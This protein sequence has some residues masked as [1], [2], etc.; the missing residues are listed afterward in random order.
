MINDKVLSSSPPL[1]S[2]TLRSPSAHAPLTYPLT[3]PPSPLIHIDHALLTSSHAPPHL[4]PPS[5]S[6]PATLLLTS[7]HSPQAD[8]FL[9]H[10]L[11]NA[12][13]VT[14]E[15]N[16]GCVEGKAKGAALAL[17]TALPSMVAAVGVKC[18]TDVIGASRPRVRTRVP[19][20]RHFQSAS[21]SRS[22]SHPLRPSLARP[23]PL[24]L[25][26]SQTLTSARSSPSRSPPARPLLPSYAARRNLQTWRGS[27]RAR[28][29]EQLRAPP[30]SPTSTDGHGS[31]C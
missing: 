4:L 14:A 12:D 26:P 19:R 15:A 13:I 2:L 16:V 9:D 8:G 31:Q 28:R 23:F 1:H 24:P 21:A 18:S 17:Q 20:Q 6:P 22:I 29:T 5:S 10:V 30:Q 27:P 7:S 11:P 3:V 25:Q